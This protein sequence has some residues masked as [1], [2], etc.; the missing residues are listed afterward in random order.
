MFAARKLAASCSGWNGTKRRQVLVEMRDGFDAAK[1]IFQV[2]VLVG[3][4]R[5]F[6]GQTE[7]DQDARHFER[8]VHLR[9]KRDRAAF[10]NENG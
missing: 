1:I 2:D 10:A 3:S 8:V 9:D 5:V 7:T 6:V 4:M